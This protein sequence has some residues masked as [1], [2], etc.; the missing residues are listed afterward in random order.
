MKRFI[1]STFLLVSIAASA[2]AQAS[3]TAFGNEPATVLR[4]FPNPAVSNITFDFTR[5][6]DKGYT[7]QVYNFLGRKLY[8]SV[9]VAPRTSV[10]L[11]DYNRGVYI[12]Q[13]YDRNGKMVESGK[14]Q[15]SK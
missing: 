4:F 13:L 11:A 7:I 3:R 1:L 6:Y 9:N 12:Y 2:G 5:N 10:N 8:E 15:V 14:F